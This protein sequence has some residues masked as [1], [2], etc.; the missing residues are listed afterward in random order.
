M[1]LLDFL[2][3]LPILFFCYR[4]FANG[5]IKEVLSIVGIV[6]AV[7]FTFKYMKEVGFLIRSFFTENDGYIPYI[8]APLIFI[9]TLL[10]VHTI[11]FLSTNFLDTI[12]LNFINQL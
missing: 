6:L 1:N 8:S 5:I 7:F 11:A 4:G 12:H 2:I 9:G 3:F 10:V